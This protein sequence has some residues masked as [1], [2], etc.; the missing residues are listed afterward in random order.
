[1]RAADVADVDAAVRVR[2]LKVHRT[3]NSDLIIDAHA[4]AGSGNPVEQAFP[5]R[6]RIICRDPHRIDGDCRL[7]LQSVERFLRRIGVA[8]FHFLQGM[9]G[10]ARI[11]P[12]ANGDVPVGI[13]EREQRSRPDVERSIERFLQ[14]RCAGCRR[15]QQNG[16]ED[17]QMS[18]HTGS[19][20][21]GPLQ[22]A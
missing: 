7:N 21:R 13:V 12:R 1:M 14:R 22:V 6:F 16:S 3:R 18:S 4:H 11:I 8:A 17:Q 10:N 19:I 20:R 15:G 9:H 2:E 5:I